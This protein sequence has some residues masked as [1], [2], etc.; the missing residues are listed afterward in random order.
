MLKTWEILDAVMSSELPSSVRW[1]ITVI[2]SCQ[3][4]TEGRPAFP[5]YETIAKKAGTSVRSAKENVRLAVDAGWLKVTKA[6]G[7]GK[8]Y[9]HNVYA[10]QV[11]D[12][13]PS[14]DSAPGF[15]ANS[16]P[17]AENDINQVQNLHTNNEANNR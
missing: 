12:T 2:G 3:N 13:K 7:V 4:H 5:D 9:L 17:S 11:P 15:L 10:I 8:K 1:V 6:R 16:K 14:A